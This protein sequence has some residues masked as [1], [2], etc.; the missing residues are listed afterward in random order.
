MCGAL[1][2]SLRIILPL[3]EGAGA[4]PSA[5]LPSGLCGALAPLADS[6]SA[7]ATRALLLVARQ[8][9]NVAVSL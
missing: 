6:V 1:L 8:R 4:R 7:G 2:G 3:R 5:P 9:F